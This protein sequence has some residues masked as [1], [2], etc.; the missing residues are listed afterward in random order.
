MSN[1][2]IDE[3]RE[4]RRIGRIIKESWISSMMETRG[5]SRQEAVQA[6]VRESKADW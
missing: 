3:K 1:T 5:W 6:W 2:T 4:Q